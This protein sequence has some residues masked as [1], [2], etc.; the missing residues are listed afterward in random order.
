MIGYFCKYAPIEI[1]KGFDE[2]CREIRPSEARE[3]CS[4]IHPNLCSFIK[5]AFE[6]IK[7]GD[8]SGVVLT[9]CCDSTRRLYDL[10]KAEFE[11]KFIYLLD[12]PHDKSPSAFSLYGRQLEKLIK[13]YESFS[14]KTFDLSKLRGCSLCKSADP[15]LS[16]SARKTNVLLLGAR[17]NPE[18]ESVLLERDINIVADL[19]C[20]GIERSVDTSGTI[21]EYAESLMEQYPCS[22]MRESGRRF[23]KEFL[24]ADGIIYHTIQFCDIYSFEYASVLKSGKP[25]LFINSDYSDS[26]RGQIRTRV[27][28]F[29]EE[30]GSEGCDKVDKSGEYVIGIDSGSTSTNGVLMNRKGEIVDSH[31]I[32]TG[33]KAESSAKRLYE[34]ILQ[35][36]SLE[37][38]DIASLIAT[39][40]GR[41]SMSFSD[42]TVTEISCHAKGAHYLNKNVRTILDIGG[43]DSKAISIKEDGSVNDF[44][45]NDKCAAGTGRF[46]DTIARTLELSTEELGNA[47]LESDKAIEITSMCT[48]FAESEVI[49]LIAENNELKDIAYGVCSSIASKSYSL[50][51]RV[52]I[53]DAVMMSGGV[54]RNKGVVK[55][56]EKKLGKEIYIPENP[57]LVGAIGAAAFA[58]DRIFNKK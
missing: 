17:M 33:A 10:L 20:T 3:T 6:E 35:R 58:L 48:V 22:R 8:Y 21:E 32:L 41:V 45:M 1:F 47:A 44:V 57:E 4:V 16:F 28:A 51:K 7:D 18:I 23:Q 54:A 55:A 2:E 37:K 29:L 24:D 9:T 43:Q 27:E 56:L 26:T 11:D 38:S 39:G 14:G 46:L 53:N 40:Y 49:T 30:I 42:D 5:A 13:A 15:E 52:G 31:S 34:L 19:S 25:V 12:L 50:L 36:N